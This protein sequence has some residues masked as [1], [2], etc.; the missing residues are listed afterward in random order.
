MEC[1]NLQV[2]LSFNERPRNSDCEGGVGVGTHGI[3]CK[4]KKELW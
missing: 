3:L 1:A 4:R 2:K